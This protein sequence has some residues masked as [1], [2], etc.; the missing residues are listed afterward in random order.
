[1][2]VSP[3]TLNRVFFGTSNG[4]V[5]MVDN[6]HTATPTATTL[7]TGAG[8]PGAYISCVE[9]QP[10]NDDHILVT[11][12]S[13]GVNSVWE[14][15]N[16]GFNW[17]SVEGNLPDMP[18]RWVIFNP[19]SNDQALIATELG[20][21]STDNLNGPSTNW[22]V[23]NGGLANV[24]VDMLQSRSSDNLIIA[25][26][27][28]RGLYYTGAFSPAAASFTTATQIVY[29]GRAL[30]FTNTSVNATSSSWNFGDGNTSTATNPKK[31]FSNPGTYN[32]TL[33]IN[34]GA[35][36]SIR[37]IIV[38][39]WSG[40]PYIPAD[41]GSFDLNPAHFA[42]ETIS[43]TGWEKGNSATTGKS[44]TNSGAN[45]WVTGLSGNYVNNSESYLYSPSYN[46]SSLGSYTFSFYTKYV[47]EADFDGIR[48]EYSIDTG[49]NWFPLGTSVVTNWYNFANPSTTAFPAG[50]AFFSGTNA[51]YSKKQ[52]DV[53]SLAGNDQV[54]FRFAFKTDGGVTAAG[55]AIDDVA[56][57]GTPNNPLPLSLTSFTA[58]KDGEDALLQW[59]TMNEVNVSHFD[60]ERSWNGT[61]FNF[62]GKKT[63][64]NGTSN[65]YAFKDLLSKQSRPGQTVYYRL[66]MMDRDGKFKYSPVELLRWNGLQN[67]QV[68]ISPNPFK[69]HIRVNTL[70]KVEKAE[71]IDNQGRVVAAANGLTNG[72][73]NVPSLPAGTYVLRLQTSEGVLT[74]KLVK[75]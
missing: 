1:V 5:V 66:K 72:R 48:V 68:S 61:E 38:M 28:G 52:Y 71:L 46:L 63:A 39:P 14:T 57:E 6:A 50:Q 13:Y 18:V 22:G 53:S 32:V 29:P 25:A 20:V 56:I 74:R 10:G 37:T 54:A 40:T 69:D 4:N 55:A 44:G 42:A 11:Y 23:T 21:W 12:S 41:G 16:G 3:N 26:T 30:Q 51:S 75:Q 45:A 7:N 33:S 34:G 67:S 73:L 49:K 43:G 2:K 62:I 70:L 19:T 9:V 8:M 64:L 31:S 24:R 15:T 35:S 27:H 47:F 65:N 58:V 36:T 17:S 60:I 59:Q